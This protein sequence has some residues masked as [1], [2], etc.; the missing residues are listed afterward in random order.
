MNEIDARLEALRAKVEEK[1]ATHRYKVVR[2]HRSVI[3]NDG[4]AL[5][6]CELM[7]ELYGNMVKEILSML[8]ELP[9]PLT[10]EEKKEAPTD[11]SW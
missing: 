3:Q 5:A 1:M 11:Y 9:E 7:G 10:E 4:Q 6:A 2:A 8:H